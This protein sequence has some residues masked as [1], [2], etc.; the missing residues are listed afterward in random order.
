MKLN[1]KLNELRSENP[2]KVPEGYFENFTN[3]LM[4]RLPEREIK[5]PEKVNLWER[6][7]PWMYM[8]AMFAGI[9]LMVR[10]FT[11]GAGEAPRILSE[12]ETASPTEIEEFYSFYEDQYVENA[13]R[14]AF[15]MEELPAETES[16]SE[17]EPFN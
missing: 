4:S 6:F 8:A 5:E 15:F 3:D 9:A 16:Y 11:G 12:N 1:N 10:M 2:F 14:Q 7:K 17:E 13:Y